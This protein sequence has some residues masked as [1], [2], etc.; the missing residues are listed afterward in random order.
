[1]MYINTGV[2]SFREIQVLVTMQVTSGVN[3][4]IQ[5]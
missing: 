4:E 1:M 3:K 2:N 5:E